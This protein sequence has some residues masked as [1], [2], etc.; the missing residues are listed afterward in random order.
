MQ[1]SNAATGAVLSTQ[2][3]SSF[4]G[5][6]YLQWTVSGNVAITITRVSGPTP[7]SAA[8]SSTRFLAATAPLAHQADT[9]TRGT[10]S[11]PTASQGYDVIG[12]AASLPSYATVTPRASRA[13]PGASTTDP[14][15]L[16]T[17]AAPAA[18]PP[19]GTRRPASRWMWT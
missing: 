5:G 19:P 10:G 16:Q 8:C 14:R 18:S 9:T 17:P 11:G 15:A 7:C 2:T 13:T 12:N 6:D 4:A 3:V 1:I